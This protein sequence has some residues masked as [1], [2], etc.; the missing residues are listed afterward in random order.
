[1]KNIFENAYFGKP[2]KTRDGRKVLFLYYDYETNPH[3]YNCWVKGVGHINYNIIGKPYDYP[4][5]SCT[6]LDIISEWQEEINEKELDKLAEEYVEQIDFVDSTV[7]YVCKED[8][9]AGYRK[10]ME[11]KE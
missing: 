7:K 8:F 10:A 3:S 11:G 2:Y 4:N 1:M 5:D 9:K 6:E